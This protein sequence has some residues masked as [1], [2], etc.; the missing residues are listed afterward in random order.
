MRKRLELVV[1][2]AS[3]KYA[4]V[5]RFTWT[6]CPSMSVMKLLPVRSRCNS[7]PALTS[8]DEDTG[9]SSCAR[10]SHRFELDCGPNG[11]ATSLPSRLYAANT[12]TRPARPTGSAP[13]ADARVRELSTRETS[14]ICSYSPS[15]FSPNGPGEPR[16]SVA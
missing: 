1:Q 11:L 10:P 8:S 4:A 3:A 15:G 5:R 6:S 9:T 2:R 14:S 7:R 12:S 16:S 13:D